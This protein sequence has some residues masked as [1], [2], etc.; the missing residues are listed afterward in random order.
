MFDQHPHLNRFVAGGRLYER[1]G[2]WLVFTVKSEFSEDGT[3]LEVKHRVDPGR[4]FVELVGD[5]Q[6]AVAD[7]RAGK[8]G[9]A[10]RELALFLRLP[11]VLRRGVVR[12]A[13]GAN[14]LNLLP[15][16]FIEGDP[17]FASAFLTNLGSV[18]LDSAFHHL[19]EYGTIPIF[20][21]LGR[22][23]ETVE[24]TD[25]RPAVTRTASMKFTYDERVEDGF[26]AARALEDFRRFVE[27]P[28]EG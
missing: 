1:D 4:S 24:V 2:I 23:H 9:L 18:G 17:F 22:V 26:Y 3:L 6:A 12:A 21:A 19:Y 10:D 13:S 7:A 14:A 8:E 20:G 28:G 5:L 25:G 11:A 27:H 16:S 15:R